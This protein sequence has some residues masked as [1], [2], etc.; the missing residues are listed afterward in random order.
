MKRKAL[1]SNEH[2]TLFSDGTIGLS[3][4]SGYIGT[5]DADGVMGLFTALCALYDVCEIIR[6]VPK[7]NMT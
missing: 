7:E 2:M 3:D 1:H 5:I 6:D 4:G